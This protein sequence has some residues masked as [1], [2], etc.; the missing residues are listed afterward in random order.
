MMFSMHRRTFLQTAVAAAAPAL[1]SPTPIRLGLD[2]YSIRDFRWKAMQVLDYAAG[3]KLAAVQFS[4]MDDYES[5]DLSHLQKVKDR[6]AQL[7]I[8]IDAGIGCICPTTRSWNPRNGNPEK[9]IVRG[10]AVARAVGAKAMRCFQGSTVD[11]RG[12]RPIEAHMEMTMSVLRSVRQPALDSGVKIAIENHGDM[13]AREVKAIIE[14]VGR[15]FVASC[16]DVGNPM[17]VVEDPLVALETLAPYVATT[18]VRDSVVYEHP[19]GAA[20]QWVAIG[21]GSI[22]LKQLVARYRQLCPNVSMQL[23][24]ITGRPPQV[25]PYLE[26]D[27]WKAFPNARASEFARFVALAK[28]GHPFMGSM[29]IAGPGPQ[30][31]EIQAALKE[32]QRRDLERSVEYTRRNLGL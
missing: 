17:W 15:D 27:F 21:D 23:E 14:E 10:L 4:S 25:M 16:L 12:P 32:Q 2:P 3:L 19:R 30:P 22:D 29:V 20:W 8:S 6:A 9:Y 1:G 31:P 5:L 26:P 24:I 11:R 28:N 13:Q 18:H 7:G